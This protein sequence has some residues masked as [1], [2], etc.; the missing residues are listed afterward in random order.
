MQPIHQNIQVT[1]RYSVYFTSHLFAHEN[2]LLRDVVSVG[3][4]ISPKK[5]L[6]VVDS[7]V[8][9][10]HPSLLD[11]IPSYCRHHKSFLYLVCPPLIIE[12][13]EGAKNDPLNVTTIQEA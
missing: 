13:G 5:I 7:L 3:D 10:H 11:A 8:C 1:Y 4:A 2:S 12:G 6:C 9:Q